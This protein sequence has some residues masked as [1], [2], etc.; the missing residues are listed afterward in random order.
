MTEKQAFEIPR[1]TAPACGDEYRTGADGLRSIHGCHGTGN[2]CMV[3]SLGKR[4]DLWVSS[5][6]GTV[7]LIREGKRRG[8]LRAS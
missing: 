1:A 8:R 6:S 5:R 2:E 4:D 7:D 3:I